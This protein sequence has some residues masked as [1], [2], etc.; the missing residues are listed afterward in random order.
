MGQGGSPRRQGSSLA[1]GLSGL[2]RLGLGD[3]LKS[4]LGFGKVKE[5]IT[6][7]V[8]EVRHPFHLRCVCSVWHGPRRWVYIVKWR[9]GGLCMKQQGLVQIQD[10]H[11]QLT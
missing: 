2:P 10:L 6:A 4:G 9:A 7:Q 5:A 1:R 8:A 11:L 3:R